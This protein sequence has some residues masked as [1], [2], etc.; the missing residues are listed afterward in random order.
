M[1][2][3]DEKELRRMKRKKKNILGKTITQKTD[4]QINFHPQKFKT[5][6]N[7]EITKHRRKMKYSTLLRSTL[8]LIQLTFE[9]KKFHSI[10]KKLKGGHFHLFP[11]F[12][13]LLFTT[14]IRIDFIMHCTEFI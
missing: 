8:T 9:R 14:N 11:L 13:S 4:G 7:K 1:I 3:V 5:H 10:K 6:Y 12:F 2:G